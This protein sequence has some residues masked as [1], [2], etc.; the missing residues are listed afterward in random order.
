MFGKVVRGAVGAWSQNSSVH[1]RLNR[2]RPLSNSEL[3]SFSHKRVNEKSM[4]YAK[5]EVRNGE[6]NG[7]LGKGQ[8]LCHWGLQFE[9]CHYPGS[10]L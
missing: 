4:V 6:R 2:L 7:F 8:S 5:D 9:S 10:A 1:P 3:L